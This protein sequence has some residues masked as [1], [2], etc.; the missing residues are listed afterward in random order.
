MPFTIP[1]AA[2]AYPPDRANNRQELIIGNHLLDIG[3]EIA[4]DQ[5]IPTG[6]EEGTSAHGPEEPRSQAHTD[7][8]T[9]RLNDHSLM[10]LWY[11]MMVDLS[12]R[13]VTVVF[14]VGN[15]WLLQL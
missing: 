14:V 12:V 1:R 10:H 13:V 4:I 15:W 8:R 5:Q 9:L 3:L 2:I 6:T 11:V 7:R